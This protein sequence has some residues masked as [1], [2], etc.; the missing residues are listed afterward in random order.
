MCLPECYSG[1]RILLIRG[2]LEAADS[3]LSLNFMHACMHAVFVKINCCFYLD[4]P[5]N[6][7]RTV[8]VVIIDLEFKGGTPLESGVWEP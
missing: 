4:C 1:L 5:P 2:V 3:L 8:I 7:V 6:D